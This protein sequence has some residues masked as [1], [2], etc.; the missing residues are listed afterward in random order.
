MAQVR[1]SRHHLRVDLEEGDHHDVRHD[2]LEGLS[3]RAALTAIGFDVEPTERGRQN[4]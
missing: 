1:P 2:R 4:S 3:A